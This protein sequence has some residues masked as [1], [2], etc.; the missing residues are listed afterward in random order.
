M[1]LVKSQ[2]NSS[3]WIS[4]TCINAAKTYVYE[5]TITRTSHNYNIYLNNNIIIA[6][7]R[8]IYAL[9]V[10]ESQLTW[11]YTKKISGRDDV[12]YNQEIGSTLLRRKDDLKG[13]LGGERYIQSY[14]GSA[15][16]K[17]RDK[18]IVEISLRRDGSSSFSSDVIWRD[19][20]ASQVVGFSQ[21]SIYLG[22]NLLKRGQIISFYT[23][24]SRE[25]VL[26]KCI[27]TKTYEN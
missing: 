24:E 13:F 12:D 27:K 25:I 5:D 1:N 7:N 9:M 22:E 18:Y 3:N 17:F 4:G 26:K 2:D 15:N 19:F 14:F 10:T 16:Y 8:C 23:D 6:K 20:V 21:M 11:L